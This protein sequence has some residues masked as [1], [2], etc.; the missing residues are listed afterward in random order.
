MKTA[1]GLA[2]IA[3]GAILALAVHAST[4]GFNINLAG[5][6]IVAV[7]VA[8]L[9]LQSRTSGWLRRR[10]VLH[11]PVAEAPGSYTTERSPAYL[12]EDPATIVDDPAVL[13]AEVLGGEPGGHGD[14]RGEK[15]SAPGDSAVQGSRLGQPFRT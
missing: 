10:V 13:A 3:F 15:P 9:L 8:G 12:V 14:A 7:G 6:I 11:G 1:T 4:P 5:L 2:V